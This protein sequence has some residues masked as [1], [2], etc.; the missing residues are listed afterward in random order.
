MLSEDIALVARR[1]E[2]GVPVSP[3]DCER[4]AS[5]LRCAAADAAQLE[6]IPMV[7]GHGP[8]RRAPDVGAQ[9]F[10]ALCATPPP[11]GSADII[12][13]PVRPREPR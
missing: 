2:L 13:F 8:V 10:A 1:L 6:G 4:L 9:V 5:I 3:E 12:P 7:L 11:D